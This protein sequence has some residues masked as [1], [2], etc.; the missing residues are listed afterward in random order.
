MVKKLTLP[1]H[2]VVFLLVSSSVAKSS[3]AAKSS[4]PDA[5]SSTGMLIIHQEGL[6]QGG[7]SLTN[8][9]DLMEAMQVNKTEILHSYNDF[10]TWH[11][12]SFSLIP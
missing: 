9:E 5:P 3:S 8:L 1:F 12:H 2:V 6:E 10:F 4:S 7:E 11:I